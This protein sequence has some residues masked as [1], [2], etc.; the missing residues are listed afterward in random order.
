LS[1]LCFGDFSNLHVEK[2]K[3]CLA[4]EYLP[5]LLSNLSSIYHPTNATSSKYIRP[6]IILFPLGTG[7]ALF[8]SLHRPLASP[9]TTSQ[10]SKD[11]IDLVL[12]LRTL[13]FGSPSSLP[14][15]RATFSPYSR[16][17]SNY[18]R[19]ALPLPTSNTLYGAIVASY[20]LHA[21]LVADS[22]TAEWRQHGVARFGM[23]AKELLSPSDGGEPH[24]YWAKLV[25]RMKEGQE[26]VVDRQEHGY[27][28]LTLV[29]NLEK[30]FT[31]SPASKPL[32]G[33]LRVVH[34]GPETREEVMRI[35]ALAYQGGKHVA[36]EKVAYEEVR[37][38]R[39]EFLERDGDEKSGGND[40]MEGRWRRVCID[41]LIVRVEEGGWMEV[42]QVPQ[43]ERA[44]DIV[45]APGIRG[46]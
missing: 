12:A 37:G 23:V 31:I 40:D 7:N 8:H 16:L 15:F 42:S 19:S 24:A 10:N 11:P 5:A 20:G 13:L 17:L 3:R 36:E 45:V 35:M 21:T 6:T 33:K 30:T 34:F 44:V 25:M 27:I 41:G 29:S 32:D 39:I 18:G 4:L 43:A 22:D 9:P 46:S 14:V 2:Q 38:M 1:F 26:V 28:L